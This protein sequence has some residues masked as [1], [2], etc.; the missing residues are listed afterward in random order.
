MDDRLKELT[1]KIYSEGVDKAEKEAKEI[2]EKAQLEA[3]KILKDS[4]KEAEEIKSKA[5]K[6]AEELKTN[7]ESEIKLSARQAINALKQNIAELIT[8]KVS[9]EA[10]EGA[11]SDKDFSKNILEKFISSYIDS[12]DKNIDLAV[13]IPDKQKDEMNKFFDAQFKD[14]LNK[15]LKVKFSDD[16][17]A[18]FE[19]GPA[20]NSYKISFTDETFEAFFKNYLR[21]R[22]VKLLYD[23]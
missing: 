21:P 8:V 22:S 23:K 18:G 11:I 3:D 4:K 6:E 20:D 16:I 13:N 2:V 17:N 10:T 14:I 9:K 12:E 5:E 19:I 7:V 1:N 15:G